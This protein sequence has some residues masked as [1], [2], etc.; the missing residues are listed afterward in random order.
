MILGFIGSAYNQLLLS[1]MLLVTKKVNRSITGYRYFNP[2][3]G[4]I[5]SNFAIK[6]RD[7]SKLVLA[8]LPK[9]IG[10]SPIIFSKN[11]PYYKHVNMQNTCI[12]YIENDKERGIIYAQ[13][14]VELPDKMNPNHYQYDIMERKPDYE[15]ASEAILS[16]NEKDYFLNIKSS[17]SSMWID[18]LNKNT[19]SVYVGTNVNTR[20]VKY[21][22]YFIEVEDKSFYI[23]TDK[24]IL[25]YCGIILGHE[26]PDIVELRSEA[27]IEFKYGQPPKPGE[28]ISKWK[29]TK[30]IRG[31]MD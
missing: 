7:F 13:A 14:G 9:E 20:I 16:G 1:A 12:N 5:D 11:K 4:E 21:P 6:D 15:F 30:Q 19:L 3:D 29:L 24:D 18:T 28:R 27:F 22:V 31:W 2:M 23:S 25:K 8:G 10:D 26:K 17:I